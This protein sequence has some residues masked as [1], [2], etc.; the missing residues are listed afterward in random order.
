MNDANGL[1]A[2]ELRHLA[3]LEA[4]VEEGSFARAAARLGYTQSALSQQIAALERIVDIRLLERRRG[5]SP[6]GTTEAGALLLRHAARIVASLRAADADLAALRAG[7]AGTLRVGTFQTVGTGILPTLLARFGAEHPDV[8][9]SLSEAVSKEALLELVET[10][11]LDVSFTVLPVAAE[12]LET[13]A[14]MDD[15][16]VLVVPAGSPLVGRSQPVRRADLS[17][18]TLVAYK[19]SLR[20]NPES[21]LHTL[22]IAPRVLLRSDETATVHGLVA[23]GVASAILPRLAVDPDDPRIHVLRMGHLLPPRRIGLA[24]HRDRYHSSAFHSFVALAREVC[25]QLGTPTAP[26]ERAR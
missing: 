5:R 1:K 19:Y 18:L 16:W 3:A 21:Y 6:L 15:P 23:A 12:P 8:E 13:E 11:G 20:V 26:G 10:G 9:V 22:G 7:S 17:G 14:L 25:A 4:V 24:W 2:V